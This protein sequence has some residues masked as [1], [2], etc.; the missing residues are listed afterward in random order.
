MGPL[1][2]SKPNKN[3]CEGQG[4]GERRRAAEVDGLETCGS[5]LEGWAH[6]C[7]DAPNPTS[8]E[9][10]YAPPQCARSR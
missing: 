6:G 7:A 3:L 5:F 2:P 10:L 4:L 8:H 9:A 1:M